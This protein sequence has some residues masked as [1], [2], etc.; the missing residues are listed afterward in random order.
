MLYETPDE[1]GLSWSR[2][3]VRE[4]GG[5]QKLAERFLLAVGILWFS[6]FIISDKEKKRITTY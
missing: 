2:K 6:Y 1:L 3:S 5:R 4:E